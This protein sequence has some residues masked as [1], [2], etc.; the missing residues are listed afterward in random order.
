MKTE[1][2][3]ERQ[4]HEIASEI[5]KTWASVNFAAKPYL[6]AMLSMGRITDNYGCDDGRSIVAYFLSNST[7]WRGDEARRIKAELKGM[8]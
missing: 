6:G 1:R 2:K 4:L 3:I 8:L 7:S 5:R